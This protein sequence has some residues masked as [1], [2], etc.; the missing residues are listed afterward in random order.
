MENTVFVLLGKERY[1]DGKTIPL[2]ATSTNDIEKIYELSERMFKEVR[3]DY[4]LL[5]HTYVGGNLAEISTYD[6]SEGDFVVIT[7][8]EL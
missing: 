2:M 6:D 8:F 1:F 3:E 7:R 4:D 5:L